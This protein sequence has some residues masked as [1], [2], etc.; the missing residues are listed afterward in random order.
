MYSP[1]RTEING[2]SA[3]WLDIGPQRRREL[4]PLAH[5]R[6]SKAFREISSVPGSHLISTVIS[7][8]NEEGWYIYL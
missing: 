4:V 1:T 3:V 5:S 7:P 8:R 2:E 6:Q